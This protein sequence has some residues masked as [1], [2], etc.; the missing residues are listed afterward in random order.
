MKKKIFLTVGIFIAVFAVASVAKIV[1]AG[2]SQNS[3]GWLWGGGTEP[4]GA[5][6]WDGTHTN[7][8][9][10]SMNSQGCDA[11]SNGQ[12]DGPINECPPAGTAIADYGVNIP[13]D[14]SSASGYAW[15]RNVGWI[16][17]NAPD[18]VG[19]PSGACEA[20]LNTSTNK[21]EGW[22]RIIGIKDAGANAGGWQGWI[23]LSGL[24]D[25]GNQPYGITFNGDGTAAASSYAWSDELGWVDFSRMKTGP[26]TPPAPPSID[27]SVTPTIIRLSSGQ[28]LGSLP[29][30]SKTVNLNWS[31]TGA[32][33]CTATCVEGNCGSWANGV[34]ARGISGGPVPIE[35]STVTT[36]FRL[37]CKGPG[38]EDYA[39]RNV[40]VGCY[41][42]GCSSGT[43]QDAAFNATEVFNCT[44]CTS[45]SQ[46]TTR[47][48]GDYIEVR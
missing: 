32:T 19:C 13:S 9:W 30:A 34:D 7:F 27:F 22:A 16:S 3:T 24:T 44:G 10:V 40:I 31:T 14:G 45:D 20:K 6:P 17:F 33:S 2:T 8:G 38:G 15:S 25:P 5:Q 37:S 4:D 23:K 39:D 41:N 46:C 1:L 21:L 12:S 42:K 43:C 36:N 11:D 29:A 47:N 48:V 28:I 18:L 26:I 35:I